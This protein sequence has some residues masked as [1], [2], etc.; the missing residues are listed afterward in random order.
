MPIP[1]I[2]QFLQRLA[3]HIHLW[4]IESVKDYFESSVVVILI[5]AIGG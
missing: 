5:S 3:K 4:F 1:S 2:I